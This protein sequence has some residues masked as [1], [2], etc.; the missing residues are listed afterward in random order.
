MDDN[1]FRV[2]VGTALIFA[3]VN[4]VHDGGNVVATIISS[5]SMRR[6]RALL[7]ATLAEFLG[8]IIV[9][10]AVAHTIFAM[11]NP[12]AL[13]RLPEAP[14]GLIVIS[15]SLGA[16]FW[17][18]P[19]WFLGLPSS[20]SHAIISGLAGAALVAA[21]REGVDFSQVLSHVVIPLVASPFIGLILGYLCFAVIR[22]LFA[23]SHRSIGGL[24]VPIRKPIMLALA[25]SHG[26]NDAQK[27][28]GMIALVLMAHGAQETA[29]D[30]LP[31]W[32][33][34]AAAADLAAGV[35]VGG[36]RIVKSV[37]Y[38]IYRME[39]VYSLASLLTS[40]SVV[41]GASILGGPVSTTQVVGS[42]VMGVGASRRLAGVRWNSA[43]NMGYA[44]F[45]TVPVC[46]VL[47]GA[48]FWVLNMMLF[49]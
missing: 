22:A 6:I 18:L 30:R 24:F 16:I 2:A 12:E 1:L 26:S 49:D 27:T 17:K 33:V 13:S 14:G 40:A 25:A 5:R 31:Q 29:I 4:G 38:D 15:A 42:S 9:G 7:L 46:A 20:S 3:F 10:T 47:S 45:M 37:G 8:P 39:P 34:V 21:G 36:L 19:T 35:T 23:Q 11:L 43:R 48:I 44:W 41:L 32:V 28:M